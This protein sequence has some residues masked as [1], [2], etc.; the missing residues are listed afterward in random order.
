MENLRQVG[1][2][3]SVLAP[4]HGASAANPAALRTAYWL[5]G[6]QDPSVTSQG[7]MTV[8]ATSSMVNI[9]PLKNVI[10]IYKV[11]Y[12][13]IRLMAEWLDMLMRSDH[14]RSWP[15]LL[16]TTIRLAVP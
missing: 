7:F 11:P 13:Q 8:S 9:C 10:R 14:S 1:K 4:T 16:L 6:L 3:Q 15:Q 12:F 2:P 5:E